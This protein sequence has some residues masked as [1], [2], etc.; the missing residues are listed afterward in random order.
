VERCSILTCLYMSDDLKFKHSFTCIINVPSRSGKSS[1]CVRFLQNL[2]ALCTERDF[3]GGVIWCYSD[4][5]AVPS[6]T[7]LS[8][9]NVHSNEGVPTDFQ[10]TRGR[11]CLVI[12]DDLLNDVY[13]K[14]VYYLFTKGSHHR[15]ISVF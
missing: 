4:K 9:R 15:N 3:E 13:S 11:P 7:E 5:T 10:N 2:D 8:K 1:L 6:P 12:L 14:Q